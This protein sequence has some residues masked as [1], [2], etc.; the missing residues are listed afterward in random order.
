[1]L[2]HLGLC[3]QPDR[4]YFNGSRAGTGIV[5]ALHPT[6][7]LKNRTPGPRAPNKTGQDNAHT[8]DDAKTKQ[9]NT[10]APIQPQNQTNPDQNPTCSLLSQHGVET[11]TNLDM[12]LKS[13]VQSPLTTR[14]GDRHQQITSLSYTLSPPPLNEKSATHNYP[15]HA[16]IYGKGETNMEG[17]K[18]I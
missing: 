18:I 7:P 5:P 13:H 16:K 6:Y 9:E 15:R 17:P 14:S 3:S 2:I 11:A 1:M 12:R 4:T 8:Q 10:H